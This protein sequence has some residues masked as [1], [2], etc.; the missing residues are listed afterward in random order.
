MSTYITS[1]RNER[2][3]L[4]TKNKNLKFHYEN[5]CSW[6]KTLNGFGSG[7]ISHSGIALFV[8]VWVKGNVSKQLSGAELN[9]IFIYLSF[10]SENRDRSYWIQPLFPHHSGS[11]KNPLTKR[12]RFV[13][14]PV[15]KCWLFLLCCSLCTWH[16]W[17]GIKTLWNVNCHFL[18]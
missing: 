10:R 16:F 2:T 18:F 14:L 9:L 8:Y 5:C 6:K 1:Y 12:R 7:G 4:Y 11:L 15:L 17:N 3:E 13:F